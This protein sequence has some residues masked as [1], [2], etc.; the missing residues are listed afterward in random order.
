[1]HHVQKACINLTGNCKS[2]NKFI[3][4]WNYWIFSW[5]SY[6]VFD[7]S[8]S[9]WSA[10][11]VKA[12]YINKSRSRRFICINLGSFSHNGTFKFSCRPWCRFNGLNRASQWLRFRKSIRQN[13]GSNSIKYICMSFSLDVNIQLFINL[14]LIE[15][16]EFN[17]CLVVDVSRGIQYWS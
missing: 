3:V 5:N 2:S 9:D 1:M 6:R 11:K 12:P 15:Y 17:I 8:L 4:L 16:S 7:N 10:L 13:F 14:L